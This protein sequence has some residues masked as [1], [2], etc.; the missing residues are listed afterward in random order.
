[1]MILKVTRK[2]SFTLSSDSFFLNRFLGLRC[3]CICVHVFFFL[4][5][6]LN[7]SFCRISNFSFYLKLESAIYYEIVIFSPNDSP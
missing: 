6:T 4:N 2:Q 3:V 7:I 1:M 5:E